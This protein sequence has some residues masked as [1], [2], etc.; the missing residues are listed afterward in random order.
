MTNN[1][2]RQSRRPTCYNITFL[3]PFECNRL[4]VNTRLH[5]ALR[6]RLRFP[7]SIR[8]FIRVTRTLSRLKSFI[9]AFSDD[10]GQTDLEAAA[11]AAAVN[12]VTR[13][14]QFG[15]LHA[16]WRCVAL[17]RLNGQ[18]VQEQL[19]GC[20]VFLV[21]VAIPRDRSDQPICFEM[22]S[23]ANGPALQKRAIR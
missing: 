13:Y 16:G 20:F 5:V 17:H 1:K 7:S 18:R 15:R 21:R 8:F 10:R 12:A 23:N 14:F 11:A 3:L 22:Y 19:I 2:K 4:T 9:R 6:P